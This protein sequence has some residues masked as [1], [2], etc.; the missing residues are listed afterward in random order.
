MK[1]RAEV[2]EG[3]QARPQG[4]RMDHEAQRVPA[5]ARILGT[6]HSG[7]SDGWFCQPLPYTLFLIYPLPSRCHRPGWLPMTEMDSPGRMS[8][9]KVPGDRALSEICRGGS[10]LDSLRFWEPR[11]P[12]VCDIP[13]PSAPVPTPSH[14][15]SSPCLSRMRNSPLLRKTPVTTGRSIPG[16]ISR[17]KGPGADGGGGC[18]EW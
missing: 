4:R 18:G 15:I 11:C 14:A 3:L 17:C 16:Q 2:S 8:K 9:V 10:F 1:W 5:N 13:L 7:G 12:L 6:C